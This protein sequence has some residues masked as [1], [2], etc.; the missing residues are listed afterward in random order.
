MSNY[1]IVVK[2]GF[3]CDEPLNEQERDHL[4]QAIEVDG[5]GHLKKEGLLTPDDSEAILNLDSVSLV[6]H[7]AT[8]N[9]SFPSES[10]DEHFKNAEEKAMNAH[11]VESLSEMNTFHH[12]TSLYGFPEVMSHLT[13]EAEVKKAVAI[14]ANAGMTEFASNLEL[15]VEHTLVHTVLQENQNSGEE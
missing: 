12:D 2:L 9:E 1:K 13:D 15:A 11:S 5:V 6:T 4:C 3:T 8:E 10:L 14:L 7:L